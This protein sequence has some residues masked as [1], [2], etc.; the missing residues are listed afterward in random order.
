MLYI[1]I[2][3]LI[4][5]STLHQMQTSWAS[6]WEAKLSQNGGGGAI[7]LHIQYESDKMQEN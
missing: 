3:G 5:S 7:I 1:P 6:L 2:H 4:S